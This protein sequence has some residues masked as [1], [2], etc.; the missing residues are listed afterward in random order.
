[1]LR[2]WLAEKPGSMPPNANAAEAA[3][4]F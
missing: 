4:V 1:M 2:Y 3:D